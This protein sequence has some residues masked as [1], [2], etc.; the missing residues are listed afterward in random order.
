MPLRGKSQKS[1][2]VLADL[3]CSE[4]DAGVERLGFC[5]VIGFD[6]VPVTSDRFSHDL[7]DCDVLWTEAIFQVGRGCRPRKFVSN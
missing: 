4:V 2:P 3:M 6:R 1:E 5:L 7:L